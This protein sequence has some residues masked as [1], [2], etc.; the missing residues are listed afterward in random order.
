LT[1]KESVCVVDL[2]AKP[3]AHAPLPVTKGA[4]TLTSVQPQRIT[5]VMPFDEGG[6][7]PPPNRTA[8]N[9]AALTIWAGRD[10]FLVLD[11]EP[12][13]NNAAIADQTDA[14]AVFDLTGT[15][16][17]AALSRLC[18]IDTR[19][20]QFK[21]GHTARTLLGHVN[22]SISRLDNTT[23]RILV[24]RSMAQTAVHDLTRAMAHAVR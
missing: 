14:W 24:P 10:L 11:G 16:G 21:P 18:P 19:P 15:G 13:R 6:D 23:L 7:L 22:A 9:G 3:P 1:P 20:A 17:D 8:R 4:L 5:A 2:I 12:P